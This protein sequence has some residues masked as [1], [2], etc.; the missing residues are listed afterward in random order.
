MAKSR[1]GVGGFGA[2]TCITAS[3]HK[4]VTL[5]RIFPAKAFVAIGA[6]ERLDSK[7]DPLVSLQIMIAVKTLRALITPEWPLLVRYRS[8]LRW[9][10]V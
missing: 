4:N 2:S 5:Q 8:M 3:L 10:H 6:R 7:V 9:V 1:S